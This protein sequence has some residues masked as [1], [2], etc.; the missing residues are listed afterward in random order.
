MGNSKPAAIVRK[1]HKD[2][3]RFTH[4]SGRWC[5]K[6]RGKQRCFGKT[7]DDSK[8]EAALKRWLD[9]KGD[10]LATR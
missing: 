1:P 5:K 8:G 6:V 4:Q 3:P 7:S 10:L 2:F 9:Q